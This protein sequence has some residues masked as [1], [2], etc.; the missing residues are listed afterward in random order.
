MAGFMVR[1][2]VRLQDE[3]ARLRSL[4]R[5]LDAAKVVGQGD[6]YV[7]PVGVF[8]QCMRAA[9]APAAKPAF[10]DKPGD[11]RHFQD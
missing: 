11:L 7:L 6:T 3:V 5:Y 2:N 10:Q 1:E 8:D 4:L 9:T